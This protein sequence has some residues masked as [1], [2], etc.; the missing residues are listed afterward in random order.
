MFQG[1]VRIR[2]SL[3]FEI[4]IP[5]IVADFTVSRSQL[6]LADTITVNNMSTPLYNVW[7]IV[8]E[9]TAG[10]PLVS[11]DFE[12]IFNLTEAGRYRISLKVRNPDFPD[13]DAYYTHAPDQ[14]VNAYDNPIASFITSP[15]P[16][17]FVDQELRTDNRSQTAFD[18]ITGTSAPISYVWEFDDG[19]VLVSGVNPSPAD[20]NSNHSPVHTYEVEAADGSVIMLTAINLHGT[21]ECKDTTT[22]TVFPLFGGTT[23]VPNAFTPNPGGSNGGIVTDDGTT[24]NDVFLPITKGVQEFKMQIFDRWGNLVFESNNRNQGWDGYDRNGN[25]VPAGVY[26]YKLVLRMSNDVRT[27]Q[28]G[29]VTLIR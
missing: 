4:E 15:F 19:T 20:P 5:P 12:P 10:V 2:T 27:T 24:I 18:V 26:V 25:L 7:S 28:V 8:N 9:S 16:K 29:D 21:L 6:C 22:V 14:F 17:V 1:V 13:E 23:K 3:Y 11:H